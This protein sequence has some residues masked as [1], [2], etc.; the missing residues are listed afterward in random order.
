MLYDICIFIA[1]FY[2]FILISHPVFFFFFFF[3]K[4]DFFFGPLLSLVNVRMLN[5]RKQ[6]AVL[7]LSYYILFVTLD[8]SRIDL[9]IFLKLSS[10]FFFKIFHET[11][12]VIGKLSSTTKLRW[13][14]KADFVI[15]TFLLSGCFLEKIFSFKH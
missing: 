5:V 14:R 13:R 6:E 9:K 12:I 10:I 15:H 11:Y 1:K 2:L 4:W 8:T 7:N 3:C